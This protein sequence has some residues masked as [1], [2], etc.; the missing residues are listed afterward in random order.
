M[1]KKKRKRDEIDYH[2]PNQ[3][4]H[5]PIG[6][7][8]I[9]TAKPFVKSDAKYS[10]QNRACPICQGRGFE[11]GALNPK[12]NYLLY[13]SSSEAIGQGVQTRRCLNCDNLQFFINS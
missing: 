4:I 5:P 6:A 10:R 12:N 11:W 2:D 9:G 1:K 13:K 7:N 8:P 3:R